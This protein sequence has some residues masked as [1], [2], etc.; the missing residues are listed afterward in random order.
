M[1]A[2]NIGEHQRMLRKKFYVLRTFQ[3]MFAIK[4]IFVIVVIKLFLLSFL[5]FIDNSYADIV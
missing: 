5:S 2:E 3:S 4:T 1:A